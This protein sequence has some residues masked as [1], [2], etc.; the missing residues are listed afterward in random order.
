MGANMSNLDTDEPD[1]EEYTFGVFTDTSMKN[2]DFANAD[3]RGANFTNANLRNSNF[4]GA[5]VN[6]ANLVGVKNLD[7]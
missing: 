5:S 1:A 3:L 7:K 4:T 6:G 2:V